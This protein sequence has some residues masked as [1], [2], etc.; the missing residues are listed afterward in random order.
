[1]G[2][3]IAA[4]HR[5]LEAQ[6]KVPIVPE[7]DTVYIHTPV[8]GGQ[9][10]EKVPP[11]V[12]RDS[13]FSLPVWLDTTVEKR[14]GR[15]KLR[16]EPGRLVMHHEFEN[17]VNVGGKAGLTPFT[18]LFAGG[19]YLLDT[20]PI[21]LVGLAHGSGRWWYWAGYM[22]DFEKRNGVMVGLGVRF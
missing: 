3:Y 8:G 12:E 14:W 1:M 22:T 15:V 11:P 10:A 17:P 16:G 6:R 2:L 21:F 4:L 13:G 18:G 19:G 5:A 20:R 9:V 7:V